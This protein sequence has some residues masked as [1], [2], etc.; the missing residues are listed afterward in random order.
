VVQSQYTAYVRERIYAQNRRIM[1]RDWIT[2]ILSKEVSADFELVLARD[3]RV[4]S[5]TM[6]RSCGYANLDRI[7]RDAIS[8][9]SPFR[10]LPAS[11]GDTFTL[12]VTIHYA[13]LYD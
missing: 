7:A 3:G 6:L 11:L 13:P 1:P 2:S 8:L 10:E 5:V 9:A 12:T 4:L